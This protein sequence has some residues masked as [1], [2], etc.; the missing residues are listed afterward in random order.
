MPASCCRPQTSFGDHGAIVERPFDDG[1]FHAVDRD[2]NAERNHFGQHR[3]QPFQ[4]FIRGYRFRAIGPGGLRADVD[5]VGALGNHPPGLRQ[6]AF[7]N[8]E[9]STIG[10]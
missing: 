4:F 1:G 10:K 5:D 3:L 8:G 9:L 7:G 2:G 6:R